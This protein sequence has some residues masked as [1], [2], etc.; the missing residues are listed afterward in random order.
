MLLY[1]EELSNEG[2]LSWQSCFGTLNRVVIPQWKAIESK[3]PKAS[4][5][6][7]VYIQKN[8]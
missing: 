4:N 7:P 8:I 3:R 1:N 2:F 6:V 5:R